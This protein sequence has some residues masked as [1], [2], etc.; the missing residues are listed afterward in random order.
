MAKAKS[1]QKLKESLKDRGVIKASTK[2]GKVSKLERPKSKVD[3][4]NPYELKYTKAKHV[5]LG[6]KVKGIEGN[7]AL[8]RKKSNE[9]VFF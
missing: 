7:P 2:K 8:S 6:R 3:Q 5:I 9:I 4:V 1:I